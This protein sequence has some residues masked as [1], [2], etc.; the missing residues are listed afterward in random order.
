MAELI[1]I[2]HCMWVKI[3]VTPHRLITIPGLFLSTKKK[4]FFLVISLPLIVVFVR[5]FS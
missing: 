5:L 2:P 3:V 1:A 4:I